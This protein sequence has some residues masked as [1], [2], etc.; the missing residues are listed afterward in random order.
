MKRKSKNSEIAYI[1]H[2][3]IIDVDPKSKFLL[4]DKMLQV[5]RS[6]FPHEESEIWTNWG[7]NSYFISQTDA[8][9]DENYQ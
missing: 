5:D 8:W 3:G 6:K 4:M 2:A 7:L 1:Y 9:I